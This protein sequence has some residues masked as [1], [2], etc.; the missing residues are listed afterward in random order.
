MESSEADKAQ[1]IAEMGASKESQ[2]L[3]ALFKLIKSKFPPDTNPDPYLSR[4]LYDQVHTV[5][6]EA[7]G[8]SYKTIEV[9]GR[10][11]LWIQPEGASA[12]HV[13]AF[14]HGGGFTMGSPNGHRK[15]SAHLAKSCNC[16]ALSIDY[17]LTPEHP[18][19][20]PLDDCVAAYKW[21]LDQ[22]FSAS[23]IV[24]AGDSC[25]GGLATAVPLSAA[26][27]GLPPPGA[28]VAL[29]PWYDAT[30]SG[31][32]MVENADKDVLGSA[33]SIRE[34]ARMYTADGASPEDP[35]ISPL[36]ADPTGL[37]PHWISC[38][39]Y[40]TLRDQGIAFAEKAKAA[41]VDVVLDV[42]PEQQH[43][44]EFMAG[45]SPEAIDSL[46]RI[47]KWVRSKIGS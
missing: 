45:K 13:I 16:V 17:R 42:C 30:G 23:N 12:N 10:T 33:E 43:V 22:G 15:L 47:G 20:A 28:A 39:G 7:E 35:L 29:S 4:C 24:T 18:Y 1:S 19:P 21:L 36:F 11:A 40:D 46:Q 2:E 25:G 5:A 34:L 6:T 37:P 27:R 44:Y 32:S 9:A 3:V 26:R 14:Y 41:G 31:A 8:V 38:G